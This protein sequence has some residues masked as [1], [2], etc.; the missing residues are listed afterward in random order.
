[1]A[2]WDRRFL[3]MAARV[4]EW[5][6]DPRRRVGAIIVD[7]K[8]RVVSTG[9]NGLP[10]GVDDSPAILANQEEKLR[11]IIHAEANALLFA[12]RSV[13]G[14]TIYTTYPPC[15]QCAAM[16]IQAGIARV[17]HPLDVERSPRRAADWAS[18]TAMLAEASVPVVE[19]PVV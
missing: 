6:K 10:R 15:A 13:E 4:A 2:D 19:V 1:M 11:R 12:H 17:V 5:S 14:C 8:N 3:D 16:L 18:A 7:A 9:Y